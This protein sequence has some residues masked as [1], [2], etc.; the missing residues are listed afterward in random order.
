MSDNNTRPAGRIPVIL[1]TDIGTD[2]DDTWALVMLLNSPELDL[3]LVVTETGDTTYRAKIVARMLEIAGRT[4]VPIGIGIPFDDVFDPQ[5]QWVAGGPGQVDINIRVEPA[6]ERSRDNGARK[7]DHN[8]RIGRHLGGIARGARLDDCILR[9]DE[10]AGAISP[11]ATAGSA[12]GQ[13]NDQAWHKTQ[14]DDS[15]AHGSHDRPPRR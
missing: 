5:A 9:I 8:R 11:P 2:I 13:Q 7:R 3:R 12:P 6:I 10:A 15:S 1:D 14:S 4:D